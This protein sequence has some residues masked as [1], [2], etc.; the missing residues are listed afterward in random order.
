MKIKIEI[1]AGIA[2][3]QTIVNRAEGEPGEKGGPKG[4]LYITINVKKHS[5]FSR[6]DNNLLCDIPLSVT[7]A[8]L[9]ANVKIP[10]IGMIDQIYRIPPGTQSGT[11][12]IIKNKGF[13][14]IHSKFRGDYIFTVKVQIPKKLTKEQKELFIKLSETLEE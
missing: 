13:N 14:I 4:D 12:F 8:T 6:K 11:K 1:P 2:D 9:G 7:Q 5:K 10:M 3:S